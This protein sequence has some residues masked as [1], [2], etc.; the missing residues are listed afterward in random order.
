MVL[1]NYN[2]FIRESCRQEENG[3]LQLGKDLNPTPCAVNARPFHINAGEAGQEMPELFGPQFSKCFSYHSVEKWELLPHI[4]RQ[5]EEKE[6]HHIS[7]PYILYPSYM[8]CFM[9]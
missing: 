3:N 8:L 4:W 9:S 1:Q 2:Y 6:F 5:A 7:I